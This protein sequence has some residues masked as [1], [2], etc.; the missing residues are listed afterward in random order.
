MSVLQQNLHTVEM[1]IAQ[2]AEAAGR[3]K[4]S[5]QLVAVSKTFPADD[6]REVYAAGQRDFGENYIQ[7]WYEKTETLADLPDIVWHVIGD[8]QSNKTKYVAERAH[9]VHTVSRL[10]TAQRLSAQRPPH[11]PPLQVCIE[12][13][14]AAEPNKHG[15]SPTEAVALAVEVAKLPNLQ[16][17]GLMCVAKAESSDDELRA[18]FQNMQRLLADVN[19]AGVAADVLS[20]G[21]SADMTAAIECG[22]THVRVGSAIFGKRDYAV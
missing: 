1:Q 17:H 3:L 13:N 22:A 7:E 6:I 12:V 11:M 15:I 16:V 18:Q 2:A 10:K 20:M 19:A 21:M 5:V 14:I 4:E 9:W 8:V